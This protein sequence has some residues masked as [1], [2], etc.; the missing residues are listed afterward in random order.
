MHKVL[1]LILEAKKRR[2]ELIKN[3][4]DGFL[5]LIDKLPQPK[6]L[7]KVLKSDKTLSI[8]GEL[9]QASPSAGI[10]REE[11]NYRELARIFEEEGFAGISVLTEEEFFLG[12][13]AYIQEIK[14]EVSLPILRK[15]FIFEEIQI[16]ESRALGADAI[17]LIARILEKE[18]LSKL[19]E[20]THELEMEA[21]IEVRSHKELAR[22]LKFPKI[23]MIGINN[24]N[25]D[26]LKI[27]IK[28]TE[29][30]M[31][32]IPADMTVVSESG[33]HTLKDMLY[34]KGLS[35]DAVLIGEAFMKAQDVRAKIRELKVDG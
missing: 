10:I 26:T 1:S 18:K 33:I 22:I 23:D 24:R 29:T 3:N 2:V 25:L 7:Q 4:K 27:D 15:D 19:I 6:P 8:I 34:L 13:P 17:L 35:V 12:K 21:L 11:F 28:T 5:K 20:L 16:Y 14:E 9:K 31:P 30:L 32:F